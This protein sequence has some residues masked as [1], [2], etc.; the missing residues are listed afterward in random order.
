MP[1]A[2][3]SRFLTKS[4]F[5]LGLECPTKLFY[6][7]KRNYA[8]S[9]NDDSFLQALAAGGY[10]VGELAKLYYPE[11]SDVTT[12]DST[13]ALE[14]TGKLLQA[15]NATLF[16]AAISFEDLLVRVDILQKTGNHFN[17]IEVKAKSVNPNSPGL[18]KN[19]GNG[20]TSSWNPYLQDVSFQHH[21]LKNAFPECTINCYLMLVDKTAVAS[22]DGLNTRFRIVRHQ[23]TR[24]SIEVDTDLTSA[25]LEPRLLSLINVDDAVS[26]IE[27]HQRIDNRNFQDHIQHL[28]ELYARDSRE[29]GALGKH[30]LACEFKTSEQEIRSALASGYHEC[31]RHELDW[32]DN[33]FQTPN[34]LNIWD[35]RK[36]NQLMHDGKLSLDLLTQDDISLAEDDLPGLSRTQR[37]WM[38]IVKARE[39]DTEPFIDREGLL[40]EINTWQYPLH[41]IDF[42]TTAPALP[43]TRG[44]KP[45]ETVA[46][47]FSH[48]VLHED[49][50]VEHRGQFLQTSPGTF[51]NLEFV[52]ELK[53]QLGAD[54]GTVFRFHNHEN[55]VLVGILRQLEGSELTD[56]TETAELCR[57]IRELTHSPANADLAWTG[58]R[59]MIDLHRLSLRYY[60]HPATGGS[61]SL[62]ALLPALI[63]SSGFLQEKYNTPVYGA[64][65]G[66][67]SLNF[68]DHRWIETEDGVMVDPYALLPPL[69]ECLKDA[70]ETPI[71]HAERI[72]DGGAAMTAYGSL[73]YLQMD[74]VERDALNKALLAYCELDTLAMVMVIEAWRDMLKLV[75]AKWRPGHY[76]TLRDVV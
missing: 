55:S 25:E 37:Q 42:E 69:T 1:D 16:E 15:Q 2:S 64:V 19:N 29:Q 35:L 65:N 10:Q 24:Q 40:A 63:S 62:K 56:T 12:L 33:D 70:V 43:F 14:E 36:A 5:K 51:P 26:W 75:S 9:Q 44:M 48:H 11:G 74:D 52:R 61:N 49:G 67:P 18:M 3:R 46:F 57:F 73:Q 47:Q 21:V 31:W 32:T 7:G 66:I 72:A 17:L 34:V 13:T 71:S 53:R 30:C 59:N 50:R 41:L 4:R 22:T 6:T 54:T 38:Q 28:S 23:G 76:A 39:A 60:Y 27:T 8:N 58:S 68:H 45:Y 20:P